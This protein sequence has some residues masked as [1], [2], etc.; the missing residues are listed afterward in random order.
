MKKA[1][2]ISVIIIGIILIPVIAGIGYFYV[3]YNNFSFEDE[4]KVNESV[5]SYFNNS[6]EEARKN[7]RFKSDELSSQ[8]LGTQVFKLPVNSSKDTNL[9]IDFCFIPGS[10]NADK[11]IVLSSGVHGLE[12]FTGSAVQLFFMDH[13]IN[14]ELLEN[15]G[16][17]LIHGINPYG[18]KYIRRVTENNID[19]NRN[20][21][22]DNKLYTSKN[23]DYP[24]VYDLIN[25]KGVV[26]TG[27]LANRFYFIKAIKRIIKESMPVLRQAVLQG[28]YEFPEGLFYGGNDF[29]PQIE[30]LIPIIDTICKPYNV[31]F[32]IDLHTAYGERGKLHL[33]PN[34]VEEPVKKRMEEIFEG[35]HIDW[36]DSDD[37]Y[38]YS[39]DFAGYIGKINHDKIFIPMPFEYGTMDSQLTIGSIKSLHVMIMENQG[40]H[41]GYNSKEDSIKVKSDFLEMYYPSSDA[42][43]S[44]IMHDTKIVLDQAL[45][46][47]CEL[48][49]Q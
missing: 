2:K 24:R 13:Y 20:S 8:Y 5:L 10:E 35:L 16:V 47:F 38:T 11:I 19:L 48:E 36:G 3:A 21:D 6:Y 22:I 26:K 23:E 49:F 46:R 39:G 12:G 29:E 7:F 4:Y 17:L 34:P 9:T 30:N 18:F 33:F 40:E 44:K 28:Q 27:S 32:A 45:K 25:P 42:W 14:H 31:V 1:I 41:Y 37:F 43:R 15:T